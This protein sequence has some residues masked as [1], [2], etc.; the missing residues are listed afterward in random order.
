MNVSG[1][2][3]AGCSAEDN[4]CLPD[5]K[6]RG[7]TRVPTL[8]SSDVCRLLV[9]IPRVSDRRYALSVC[10]LSTGIHSRRRYCGE[11]RGAKVAAD[12]RSASGAQRLFTF[13]DVA[14]LRVV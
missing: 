5:P 1:A 6:R 3:T 4:N 9:A 7:Q 10:F 14:L 11:W 13:G 8:R 12:D 2:L